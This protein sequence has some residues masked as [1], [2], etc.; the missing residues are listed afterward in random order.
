V[1]IRSLIAV[2]VVAVALVFGSAS[3]AVAKPAPWDSVDLVIHDDQGTQLMILA[4]QLAT[5]TALPAQVELAVPSGL[6]LQWAGEILGGDAANDPAVTPK[7][8][9]VGTNDVYSFTLTK[10]RTAQLELLTPG[11]VRVDGAKYAAAIAWTPSQDLRELKIGFRIPSGAQLATPVEGAVMV[12]GPA[13]FNYYRSTLTNVKANQPVSF[14]FDYSVPAA[15]GAAGG[16][17]GSSSNAA[18]F[19]IIAV[20]LAIVGGLLFAVWRKMQARNEGAA[21][22]PA[23][24]SGSGAKTSSANASRTSGSSPKA[25]AAARASG[26][27]KTS[28]EPER[29]PRSKGGI[30]A[31]AVV[32]VLVVGAVIAINAS[33]KPQDAGDVITRTFSSA[34]PCT[35]TVVPLAVAQGG[36]L[37]AAAEKLFGVLQTLPSITTAKIYKDQPRIEVG[38]CESALQ[39]GQVEQALAQTGL[40]ATN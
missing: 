8:T 33:S 25:A 34:E 27:A 32:A 13:G 1:R 28:A 16:A 37:N 4:G 24:A 15:A 38:Y 12:P 21:P 20:L 9:K 35:S 6:Q 11:A 18:T 2:A 40:V 14:A 7:V 10:S 19:G 31:I 29:K 22:A 39:P 5:E 30:V 36:D 17:A 26:S 3:I 23:R